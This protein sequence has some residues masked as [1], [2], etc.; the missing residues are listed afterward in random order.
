VSVTVTPR[1][2][3]VCYS[4]FVD[5]SQADVVVEIDTVEDVYDVSRYEGT[6]CAEEFL[7]PKHGSCPDKN[8]SPGYIG[9]SFI[10]L[11]VYRP[12]TCEPAGETERGPW[13]TPRTPPEPNSPTPSSF[14]GAQAGYVRGPKRTTPAEARADL[15][16]FE[17]TLM[18]NVAC[19]LDVLATGKR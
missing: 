18:N 5:P 12:G 10:H 2:Q 14:C 9:V 1:N 11:R 4:I 8:V 13:P 17:P 6:T 19:M 16:T 7:D 15:A 3:P